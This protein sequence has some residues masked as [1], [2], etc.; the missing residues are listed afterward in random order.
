MSVTQP[1]RPP[2]ASPSLAPLPPRAPAVPP[3]LPQPLTPLV[4]R[5]REMAEVTALLG[6]PDVRLLTLSGPGGV[7]KSRLALHAAAAAAGAFP[8]GAWFVPLAPLA[9]PALVLPTLAQAFGV[10]DAGDRPLAER[11]RGALAGRHALLVLDNVEQVVASAPAVAALLAACPDLKALATSRVRLRVSGEHTYRVPPL[12]LPDEGSRP[13]EELA[14]AEAVR[15]FVAR[16]QAARPDFALTEANAMA[17]AEVCRRLDGLPLAIELAA[18]W[19]AVLPPAALLERM[20]ARL[21]LLTGG[22]RDQPARLQTMRDA[23]AWSH[24]LLEPAEQILF[25]R[26]AA[27]AGGFPLAAAEAVAGGGPGETAA[28]P[29]VLGGVASLV[30]KSLLQRDDGPGDE[31]RFG[32]LETVREYGLECLTASGEA[33][34][35]R[36]RHA[37]WCG[38]LAERVDAALSAGRERARHLDLLA[39]EVDNLR[40]ALGWLVDTGDAAAAVGLVGNIGSFWFVRGH[41]GEG[42][43]WLQRALDLPGVVAP[44]ARAKALAVLSM[45]ATFQHDFHCAAAAADEA[46]ELAEAAED[47][48]SL[49]LARLAQTIVALNT[50]AIDLAIVRGEACIE[51]YEALEAGGDLNTA[52]FCTALALRSKRDFARAET[53]LATCLASAKRRGDEYGIALGHQGLGTVARDKG[54]DASALPHFSAALAG[55]HRADEL[56]H[57]AWCLEGVALAGAG[58]DP[59]WAARLLGAAEALRTAIGAPLPPPHRPAYD[60]VVAGIRGRLDEGMFAAAWASGRSLPLP[61]AVAEAQAA[62]SLAPK[63]DMPERSAGEP[64]AGHGLT[65]RELE[66][67]RLVAAG[68]TD[69]QIAEALFLSPRTV[70]HHVATLLSKLGAPN[71]AAAVAIAQANEVLPAEP[72]AVR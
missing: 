20:E 50:G 72:A 25:R 30:D 42:R 18:G 27:F 55:H 3:P 67:L 46:A 43:A 54:D 35:V 44:S 41:L 2:P 1:D 36:R 26:L 14:A 13:L 38:L 24:D 60:R 68:R 57:A 62:P 4:G 69:R 64:R 59:A 40:A 15:L 37:A 66:V 9:D 28:L 16:A 70:H 33:D 10:R 19:A 65:M 21:P 32:M 47:Q 61:E 39:S 52:Y 63:P 45:T 71:R 58:A 17:V 34:A 22:A 6:R 12:A 51:L 5:D 8:D 56:W 11:L 31:P 48:P 49:A 23:V 53:L 7:G 29:D